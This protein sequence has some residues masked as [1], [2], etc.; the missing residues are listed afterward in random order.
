[1]GKDAHRS[2]GALRSTRAGLVAMLGAIAIA[3]IAAASASARPTP[4][5]LQLSPGAGSLSASW[6]VS[7]TY[8]LAGLRVRWRRQGD[9]TARFSP[10]IELA[11]NRRAYVIT[12]LRSVPYEV[13]V[14]ALLSGNR[15]GG[16]MTGAAT[17]LPAEGE[18]PEEEEG[19]PEEEESPVEEGEEPPDEEGESLL[20]PVWYADPAN[21]ILEEWANI[22]AEP[23]RITRMPFASMPNGRAYSSEIRNGDNPGGYGERAEIGQ[24]NPTRLGLEDRLFNRGQ[25]RWIAFPFVLGSDFPIY[26]NSWYVIAQIKQ[27]GG[28]GTPIL[29]IGSNQHGGVALFNSDTNHTSS[30]NITRWSGTWKRGQLDKV[31]LH[32]KFSPDPDVGFVELFGDFDGSGVKLLMGKTYMSTMKQI[33]GVAVKDHARIGQ[34]R[35]SMPESGTSHVYYGRYVVAKSRAVAEAYAFE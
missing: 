9:D 15:L 24:G 29:S 27:L 25:E 18:P 19:P 12:G 34:Y 16:A 26:T 17:P 33:L 14:R 32:V 1:M 31:V 10:P 7:S 8:E 30:G 3:C 6:G 28:M 4:I 35:N 23:G 20:E 2:C 5:N 13:R 11:P 22:A 21:P